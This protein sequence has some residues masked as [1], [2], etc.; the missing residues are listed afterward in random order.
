MSV[1]L[2]CAGTPQTAKTLAMN[3]SGKNCDKMKKLTLVAVKVSK[4][5][6]GQNIRGGI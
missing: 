1:D 2:G 5:S 3:T 4:F 6:L